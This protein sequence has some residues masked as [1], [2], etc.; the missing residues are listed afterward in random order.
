MS[1][2]FTLIE[3]LVAFVVAAL[4]LGAAASAFSSVARQA[5][6]VR[7]Y[8]RALNFAETKL[9]EAGVTD[10]L[11]PG[12]LSGELAGGMR[13]RRTVE[14]YPAMDEAAMAQA[15]WL[16]YRVTV[17]VRWEKDQVVSLTSVRLRPAP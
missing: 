14:P 10:V 2:G 17:E 15:R 3:V 5:S 9:A 16:P 7:D 13:W 6:L 1:K 4:A 11:E 8:S 12:V